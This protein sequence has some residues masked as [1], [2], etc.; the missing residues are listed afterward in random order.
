MSHV[1]VKINFSF[2]IDSWNRCLSVHKRLQ[3]RARRVSFSDVETLEVKDMSEEEQKQREFVENRRDYSILVVSLFHENLM[4]CF[5][6][7]KREQNRFFRFEANK[8]S[9]RTEYD[10][11]TKY[12]NIYD[13]TMSSFPMGT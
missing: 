3:I 8:Y 1:H 4:I 10:R 7:K 9:L 11:R 5:Q 12:L 6:V 2:G 13:L